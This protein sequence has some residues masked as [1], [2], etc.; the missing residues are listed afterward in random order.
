MGTLTSP[1]LQALITGARNLLNQPDPNNSFWSDEELSS[2]ANEGI[3]IY[4]AELMSINEGHFTATDD[5]DI[6]ANTETIA[7]PTDFV[8]ARAVYKKVNN[9]Y[10]IL[11]YRNNLSEGYSTQGG[12]NSETYLP[13][14]Y[15][16]G[17][18]LVL[19]PVPQFSE[20]DGIKIEY[21]QFP[22]TLVNGGDALTSQISPVFKQLIEM[23]IVY[24]AKIKESLVIGSDTT[25][26][27][28][29]N[30][31]ELTK[32]FKDVV[33]LRSKNPTAIVPFNP[34]SEGM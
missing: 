34:E 31:S 12:T 19:R 17:N 13:Y 4:F 6:V 5:L 2:Y 15:F 25:K 29:G 16:R 28:A 23:Y 26:I 32:Q 27:A 3:R 21:I 11:P 10:V 30:L 33:A 8:E 22:D 1:T 24:K 9:G 18:N 14:Y 7:L 20:T